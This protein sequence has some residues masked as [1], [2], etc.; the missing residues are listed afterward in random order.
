[1]TNPDA[2]EELNKEL[3][4]MGD[5]AKVEHESNRQQVDDFMKEAEESDAK[6]RNDREQKLFDSS[7]YFLALDAIYDIT[8]KCGVEDYRPIGAILEDLEDRSE[9]A[10]ITERA[11]E[12]SRFY[13]N[14]TR[15]L[16]FAAGMRKL[17]D[18]GIIAPSM[19]F[20]K[21]IEAFEKKT[22]EDKEVIDRA[23]ELERR[24]ALH[25]RLDQLIAACAF[26]EGAPKD[27]VRK[28]R[29]ERTK[30]TPTE[31]TLTITIRCDDEAVGPLFDK[32]TDF[33]RNTISRNGEYFVFEAPFEKRFLDE[34]QR[35][36]SWIK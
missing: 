21:I 11:N 27:L 12:S 36:F 23:E 25:R 24:D 8:K 34:A 1:M 6:A 26:V 5:P 32:F 16:E 31:D 10:A 17:M 9:V 20:T 13:K 28:F 29:A 35:T 33:P 22:A 30:R 14:P 2:T 3:N 18:E 15:V 19:S 7:R 4:E